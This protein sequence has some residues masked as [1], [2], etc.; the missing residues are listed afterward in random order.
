MKTDLKY[1][2]FHITQQN[3]LFI[4]STGYNI[5]KPHK[6]NNKLLK[7][8]CSH[9]LCQC[10]WIYI[11]FQK[12]TSVHNM[13]AILVLFIYSKLCSKVEICVKYQANIRKACAYVCVC[14]CVCV[15]LQ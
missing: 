12:R 8:K 6:N 5:Y 3:N 11:F 10:L 2:Y 1:N 15:S 4:V 7:H 14:V 13:T 9:F